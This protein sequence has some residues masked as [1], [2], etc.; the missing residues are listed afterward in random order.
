M[1]E[2]AIASRVPL[3]F[4]EF[5]DPSTSALVMWDM[6]KGLAGRANNVE[7]LTA[8]AAGLLDSARKSGVLV[9]WSRHILP[10]HELM[11]APMLLF[12]MRKQ[13]VDHPGKLKPFMN[14]G[15]P[16]TEFLPGFEPA[17]GEVV[18]EKGVPSLFVDTPFD[19]RL[20]ARG[21]RN[22][23]LTGV[24]TEIGIE[25]TARHA[26]ALGYF[27]VV[28]EDATGSYTTEAHERSLQYLRAW[29][30]VVSSASIREAW[31]EHDRLRSRPA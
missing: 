8:A 10:S 12:M 25:F 31:A 28:V 24:A 14:Q 3:T 26:S 30:T 21:I 11:P 19:S 15:A 4:A 6:Q 23:I 1:T 29:A 9:V 18:I 7:A 2:R 22:L 27:P 5:V 20:K 13:R 17:P 16:E